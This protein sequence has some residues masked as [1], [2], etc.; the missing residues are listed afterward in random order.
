MATLRIRYYTDPETG[1]PHI[2]NHEVTSREVEQVLA[3]PDEDRQGYKGARIAIGQSEAGRYLRIIYVPDP[4]PDSVFV[5]T[6]Y[7]LRG[8]ALANTGLCGISHS[9]ILTSLLEHC[10]VIG[11]GLGNFLQHIP[12]LDDLAVFETENIYDRHAAIARLAN[13]MAMRHNQVTFRDD[14]FEINAERWIGLR[15]PVYKTDK[16]FGT[17]SSS[18]IVLAVMRSE[19]FGDCFFRLALI[20]RKVGVLTNDSLV[21]FQ[22]VVHRFSLKN[23]VGARIQLSPQSAYYN[24]MFLSSENR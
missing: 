12:M 16:R 11:R 4:E 20:K 1:S 13:Q 22:S 7:Q 5:I 23:F 2:F 19:I 10:I 17:V 3:R 24:A 6:A 21:F 14:S 18:R 9:L 15:E 8:K